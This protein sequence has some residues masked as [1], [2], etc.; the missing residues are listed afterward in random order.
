MRGIS[1]TRKLL[2]LTA[3]ALALFFVILVA[4][5]ATIYIVAGVAFQGDWERVDKAIERAYDEFF[6]N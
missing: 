6:D 1:G 4:N 5:L 3:R 2:G